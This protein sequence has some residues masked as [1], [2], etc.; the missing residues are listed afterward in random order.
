MESSQRNARTNK[1]DSDQC[2]IYAQTDCLTIEWYSCSNFVTYPV[3]SNYADSGVQSI[4]IV[5][6]WT[7]VWLSATVQRAHTTGLSNDCIFKR[8][9]FE[10]KWAVPNILHTAA[11]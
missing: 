5:S 7:Y 11:K 6:E 9:V 10:T 4:F 8:Q 1:F 3:Q 2:S